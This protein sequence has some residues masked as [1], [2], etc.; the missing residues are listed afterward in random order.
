MRHATAVGL[1]ATLL[2]PSAHAADATRTVLRCGRLIDGRGPARENVAV[3]VEGERITAL[4]GFAA[5]PAG[6]RV[7]DLAGSTC[8][9]GLIDSHTHVLLQGDITSSEYDEQL[10]KESI[11]YRTIRATMAARRALE[12]GFTTIRDVETEGAMYAD[13]DVKRAIE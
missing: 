9:P 10:L 7:I 8:L 11:P 3:V 1:A 5:A 12:Q 13:V 4:G 6:A 2:C